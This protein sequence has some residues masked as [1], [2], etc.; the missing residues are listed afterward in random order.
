MRTVPG[1]LAKDGFEGVQVAALADGTAVAVKIADGADRAR[2]PVT[3]ALL[4]RAGVD[5]ALLAPLSTSAA[6]DGPAVRTRSWRP[7]RTP[8]QTQQPT[9]SK[10]ST[11]S[12]RSEHDLLG[13]H[14]VPADAYWGVHTLRACENFPITGT[15]ISAY[16][17]LIDA[18]A[19]VKEAAA[20]A[21]EDLGLLPADKADAI[22]AACR[23]IR[24]GALHDQFV[25]DVIQGGAGTSTNMN[26]NEVIANRALE[27]LG[28][29]EGRLRRPA[30]QRARQPQ[31]VDQRRLPDR[32]QRR[33]DPRRTRAARRRW[34]CSSEAFAAKADGVP[35]RREDGPHPAAGRRA[36]DAGPGV[37]GVRR[38][39]RRGPAAARRGRRRSCTRSTSAPPR[40]APASTAPGLRRDGVPAPGRDHRAA[41]DDRRPTWS[42]RPRT[43]ARSSISR[44]SSSGSRS[45]SPRAA[46]T[47]GCCPRA[48]APASTRSTCRR[49]RPARRSCPA[50][51]TRSSPRSS[52]RSPSR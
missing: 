18:L 1:L 31:P 48:R 52:T 13:D 3:L 6:T 11:V 5:P 36:D 44:A 45:S 20:R 47:C 17:H 7:N 33:H 42:R 35:R 50:R 29:R 10:G 49:C 14:D 27:L 22:A 40:S 30:P 32:R 39:A 41:P 16:P 25:V 21:N 43:A 12:T 26:A 4:A 23:E 37:R 9:T 34:R 2:M 15:P 46:T 38:H 8:H 28:H 51:S 24:A 19:A